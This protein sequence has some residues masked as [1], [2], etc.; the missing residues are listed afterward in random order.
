MTDCEQDKKSV[1]RHQSRRTR[2]RLARYTAQ[3]ADLLY[4]RHEIAHAARVKV[5]RVRAEVLLA[6]EAVASARDEA[7]EEGV[8]KMRSP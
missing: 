8:S 3:H 6:L 4:F 7:R 1:A 5:R 2:S